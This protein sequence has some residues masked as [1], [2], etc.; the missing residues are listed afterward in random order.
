MP[1][2]RADTVQLMCECS[3]KLQMLCKLVTEYVVRRREKL[4]SWA[5][6]PATL[7]VSELLL[8]IFDIK[9]LSTRAGF[10]SSIRDDAQRV[11][12]RDPDIQASVNSSRNPTESMNLQAGRYTQVS[13]D[14]A[15]TTRVL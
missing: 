2:F 5:N 9:Y 1:N 6:E 12:N 8:T 11:T 4:I 7:F 13:M 3:A 14:V 15:S 10:K